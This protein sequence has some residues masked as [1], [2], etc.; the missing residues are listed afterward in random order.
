MTYDI[1][2]AVYYLHTRKPPVYHRDLKS[3]NCLVDEFYRV[4]LCDFGIS[5]IF[6]S[7]PGIKT[8]TFSTTFW[9]APEFLHK[10]IFSDKSDVYSFGILFWEVMNRDTIPFKN[11]DNNTFMFG[12]GSQDK[13]PEIT[14]NIDKQVAN[15]MKACWHSDPDLRPTMGQVVSQLEK[16]IE[17]EEKIV[18]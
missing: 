15:L 18:K 7:L 10:R 9:M 8:K 17:T 12:D 13:R 6:E 16:I 5:K 3:S 1:A 14:E 2:R 11:T 4:K